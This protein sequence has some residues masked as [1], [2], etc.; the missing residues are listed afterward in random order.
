MLGSDAFNLAAFPNEKN[1]REDRELLNER[2]QVRLRVFGEAGGR[3]DLDKQ[4]FFCRPGNLDV[5]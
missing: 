5:V 2:R 1:R 3:I 4:P